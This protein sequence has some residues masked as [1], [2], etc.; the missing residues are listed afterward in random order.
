MFGITSSLREGKSPT[1]EKSPLSRGKRPPDAS[2]GFIPIQGTRQPQP[3][4]ALAGP[5]KRITHP[6]P[7]RLDGTIGMILK[8]WGYVERVA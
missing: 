2:H 4:H 7:A 5:H 6:T 1:I 3:P 8:E